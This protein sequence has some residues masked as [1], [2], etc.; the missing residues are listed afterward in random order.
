MTGPIGDL[1]DEAAAAALADLPGIGPAG[2]LRLLSSAAGPAHA[3][4]LVLAGGAERRSP[5]GPSPS[6]SDAA[7]QYDPFARWASLRRAGIGVTWLGDRSYPRRLAADPE[8]PAVLFWR[9]AIEALD[10]RCAA[11]VGTRRCTPDG[12]ALAAELSHDLAS[13]GVSV[14]SGL[15]LGIDAAAHRGAL[16]AGRPAATAGV[17]ASGVD[18]PYPRVHRQ[19]WEEVAAAGT[20]ISETPPGRPAQ[21]WRFPFRNRVIAGLAEV[22]VVVE[23]HI[24]GGSMHTV[25]AALARGI[26]V[27]AVPG[28]VRSPA[29]AGTNQL[30]ADG[31]APVRDVCDVLDA[32]GLSGQPRVAEPPSAASHPRQSSSTGPAVGGTAARGPARPEARQLAAVIRAVGWRPTSLNSVVLGAGLP[33][34]DVARALDALAAEG[35]V[36]EERGWWQR[37]R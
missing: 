20:V 5:T 19:L 15:A 9:G 23:S 10:G 32:L 34:G 1:P 8:P 11:V 16:C 4:E 33:L 27:R 31:A 26:E 7:R 6:W 37:R 13:A 22:V 28:P 30:L 17:A 2:L 14:V 36:V 35:A 25:D 29:S 24:A 3:W 12:A 21:A 18:V